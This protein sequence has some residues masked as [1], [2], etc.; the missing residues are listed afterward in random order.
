MQKPRQG[1]KAFIRM[2]Y[3]SPLQHQAHLRCFPREGN[4]A[5]DCACNALSYPI[6]G[7]RW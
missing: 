6:D 4:F 5:S 2:L 1:R 7:R 3:L